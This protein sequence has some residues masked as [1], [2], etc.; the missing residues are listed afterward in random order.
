MR[1]YLNALVLHE[2]ERLEKKA[3]RAQDHEDEVM[4]ELWRDAIG[5]V[6]EDDG[7]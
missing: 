1:S 2:R 3:R 4:R 5:Q 6:E 7:A